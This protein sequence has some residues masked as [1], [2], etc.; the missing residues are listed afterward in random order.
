[1]NVT[2]NGVEVRV[3]SDCVP[4]KPS[5][6]CK[7]GEQEGIFY[8]TLSVT[9][10]EALPLPDL[11]LTWELPSVDFHH[12]WNPRCGQNRALD[13]GLGSFN[14]IQ[15]SANS[16]A[17]V[18][19]L[20]NLAGDNACTWALS[21]VIHNT[22]TGGDYRSGK[23]FY[24]DCK[25]VG[26]SV[27]VVSEYELT[28][29]FDFR[30]IQY[31]KSLADVTRYWETLPGC[32]PCVV[33]SSARKPLLSSW[34]IYEIRFEPESFETECKIASDM[35]FETAIMDDGWQTKQTTAGYQNNGDWEVSE[36]KVPDLKGHVDRI[37]AMG[38]KYMAWFSVPFCGV[39]SKAYHRFKDMLL[40]GRE[41]AKWFSF[42][43]RF[44]EVREYLVGRF[45]G[46]V[47]RY[48]V[49]GLKMDFIGSCNDSEPAADILS[50]GRRDCA[51][52]G[53][54]M[55]KLLA[56]AK[57][58][59]LT[60]NP[61]ILIE[62]RQAYTGPAMRPYGN[63][64]RAV[65]CANSLGDNRIR[66][67]DVKLLA[68]NSAVHSDPITWNENDPPHSAAMQII[69]ALFSVPQISMRLRD[70][71]ESHHNMLRQQLTFM[72]ENEDVLQHG[73][74]RPL[75]PHL[76]YPLVI[77]RNEQKMLVAFYADMP[78]RF[79]VENLPRQLLLV[80][81]CYAEEL[82]VVFDDDFGAVQIDVINCLGECVRKEKMT[83]K[84]GVHR[85]AVPPAG[86]MRLLREGR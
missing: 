55:C 1:M 2:V 66:T 50:D 58:Q 14:H 83:V 49:D 64:L 8:V 15:S 82:L 17:P 32:Q 57:R 86:H 41:G 52:M 27:G 28:V 25:V 13:V 73:D 33:P 70:L 3:E 79:G 4:F 53:E 45:T 20:Y 7:P 5:L 44:P 60:I 21:D 31:F 72:K 35:G 39:E 29:R 61:D 56:E 65:D 42:D 46:F 51:S 6:I 16:G 12:K 9:S 48:G 18:F 23:T 36:E 47:T 54:G 81:G 24:C 69:H 22:H 38:M 77:S 76:L 10:A 37:H 67:L 75:Y 19:C 85:L 43:M 26:S 78:M 30:K 74:V 59:L 62:F 68:G 40:P 71:S 11:K 34:Y 80:N 63:M 84:A